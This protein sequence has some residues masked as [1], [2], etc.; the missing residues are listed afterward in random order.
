MRPFRLIVTPYGDKLFV[1][2]GPPAE[3]VKWFA[4]AG[5][6]TDPT[7]AEGMTFVPDDD[8]LPIYMWVKDAADIASLAHEL[9]HVVF[10]VM[11]R[12][13]VPLTYENDESV[14][15]LLTHLLVAVQKRIAK[16]AAYSKRDHGSSAR[17]HSKPLSKGDPNVAVAGD[18]DP[19]KP[20]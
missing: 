3:A 4:A 10:A 2:F 1:R 18:A 11:H 13:G 9:V 12:A 7:D 20:V 19:E 14:A 17:K 5:C 16:S 15:Y 8:S 6:G